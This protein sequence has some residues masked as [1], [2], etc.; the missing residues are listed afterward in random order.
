MSDTQE[1]TGNR[2]NKRH[3]GQEGTT[4]QE[5]TS[6]ESTATMDTE[7]STDTTLD[8]PTTVIEIAGLEV[9]LPIKFSAG[10]ALTE[11]QAK[12][13][14]A[15]Y[16]R[17]FTNN[18]NALAKARATALAEGKTGDKYQALSA[19]AIAA[20]Y[21]DYEP[22]VGGITRQS[23]MERIKNEAAWRLWVSMVTEHNDH[24]RSGGTVGTLALPKAGMR[25][26]PL[27]TAPIKLKLEDGKPDLDETGKQKMITVAEQ[28]DN[29]SK[30][31][32]ARADFADRIQTNIDAILAEKGK[33]PEATSEGTVV[34]S[35]DLI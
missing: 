5:P 15:A 11:N 1:H 31:L 33:K 22:A 20:L 14:D 29:I 35:A 4:G 9:T 12:V 25:I 26:V 34:G 13:L 24:V 19:S 32:L 16:Q 8:L 28:R 10:H 23:A 7:T 18:Q 27:P 17:Q 21:T 3:Q 30:A 6:Q 2:R